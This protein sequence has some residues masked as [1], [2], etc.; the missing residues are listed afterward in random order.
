MVCSPAS[1]STATNGVVFQASASTRGSQAKIGSA[2]QVGASRPAPATSALARPKGL[3]KMNRQTSAATTVG[4][5]HGSSTAVRTSPRARVTRSSARA[6]SRPAD[7]SIASVPA[8][9]PAVRPRA[10]QN[11][12]ATEQLDVVLDADERPAEPR[13]PQVVEVQ[14]LPACPHESGTAPPPRSP[15][16][17]AASGPTPAASR[18]WRRAPAASTSRRPQ[19]QPLEQRPHLGRGVVQRLAAAPA[20]ASGRDAATA[21]GCSTAGCRPATPAAAPPPR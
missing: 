7:S 10:P 15:T 18:P 14:R 5:A 9:N 17:P 2:N 4:I 8:T 3:S 20:A 6:S 19:L 11:R 12:G 13:H 1:S 21:A 16:A